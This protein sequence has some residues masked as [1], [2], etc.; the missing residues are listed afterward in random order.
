VLFTASYISGS[1]TASYVN[2]LQTGSLIT[3]SFTS[4]FTSFSGS[5]SGSNVNLNVTGTLKVDNIGSATVQGTFTNFNGSFT[6]SVSGSDIVTV[7]NVT[8][9]SVKKLSRSLLKF[10]LSTIS[11]SISAGDITAP[12]FDLTLKTSN[13]KN[14]PIT[15]KIYSFPISQ[16]WVSGNGY[17]ADNGSNLGASW[18]YRDYDGG[19]Y[20]YPITASTNI[21]DYLNTGSLAT[22]SFT[23]GGGTWYTN[24]A[25]VNTQSFDHRAS[26]IKMDVT[27]TVMAWIS[28]SIPNEGFIL[29]HSQEVSTDPTYG[30]IKYFSK[31]TNTIYSPYLNVKWDDSTFLT[32]SITTGS[33]TTYTASGSI[34]AYFLTGSI[35]GTFFSGSLTGSFLSV[36]TASSIISGSVTGSIYTGLVSG[37]LVNG[38]IS[39]S[40]SSTNNG[41]SGYFYSGSLSGSFCTGSSNGVYIDCV[42]TGSYGNALISG[43]LIS[44]STS[45]SIVTATISSRVVEGNVQG[46]YSNG[47][48][49]GVFLSGDFTGMFI[50]GSVSGS[51]TTS[52]INTLTILAS[53][54]LSPLQLNSPFSVIIKNL[55]PTY[56][57]G[58]IVKLDVYGGV[59]SPIKNFSK[60]TQ[61]SDNI[62]PKYLPT[63]SKYSI[64]DNET[65]EVLVDFDD[66]TKISC[67][68]VGNYFLLDTTGLPQER[69]FKIL[70]RTSQSGS[71]YT[72]DNNNVFKIVR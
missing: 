58:D 66:Y 11:A 4:T 45:A 24:S 3:G 55:Q 40:Y 46:V 38:Y 43:S 63:S 1:V 68:T 71:T 26:D 13:E 8:S 72:I 65:E 42:V 27:S 30:L 16:S 50:T 64:K 12:K 21:V 10:D 44:G 49:G 53:S 35:I 15:Y 59:K 62:T 29:I 67:N 25:Y 54:S 19:A 23:N 69:Q 18:N 51:Y 60:G 31:D 70:V 57:A 41:I 48:F 5:I 6:G 22:A 37:S 14:L 2:G 39:A 47:I 20:W 9:T 17:L 34:N 7:Q 28:G 56:R 32:G 33:T 52:S 36:S 61:F